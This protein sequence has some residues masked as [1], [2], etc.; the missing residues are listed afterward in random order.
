M[1]LDGKV[2]LITGSGSGIGAA[3]ATLFSEQ[4]ARIGAADIDQDSAVGTASMVSESGGEAIVIVGD[5]TSKAECER[6]VRETV[7]RFGSCDILVN[8]AGITPRY[9]PVDTPFDEKWDRVMDV[10]LKGTMLMSYYAVQQMREQG[11][12][13]IVNMASIIGLV[14]YTHGFGLSDG[15]N[16]YP[17]SKGGVVQMTRDMGVTFAQEGIRVNALCPGFAYTPLT[18]SLTEDL[19]ALARIE[20]LHPMGR[21]GQAIE[22]AQAALFLAS[23]EASFITGA[24][25]PVDGG[26]TAQ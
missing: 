7:D 17:H 20:G 4:G 13:A 22:I 9:V 5:V 12:G 6:M 19:A 25:L 15:F 1:R 23:D 24:C 10:N 16:P 2:A 21:L 18:K 26:Y 3:C 11:G 8:S 14:G